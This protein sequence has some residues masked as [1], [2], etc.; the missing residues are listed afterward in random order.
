[1]VFMDSTAGPVR[2][3]GPP[4]ALTHLDPVREGQDWHLGPGAQCLA[5]GAPRASTGTVQH[6]GGS[7]GAETPWA[8]SSAH[9]MTPVWKHG[10]GSSRM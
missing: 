6:A 3:I 10:V 4:S 5:G 1:M 8:T 9:T 7:L 2:S